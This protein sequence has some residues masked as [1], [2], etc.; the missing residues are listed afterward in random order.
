MLGGFISV[1]VEE[2]CSNEVVDSRFN[3]H[4]LVFW[5]ELSCVS[6]CNIWRWYRTFQKVCGSSEREGSLGHIGAV[7]LHSIPASIRHP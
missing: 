6:D 1:E 4:L 5:R 7:K 2:R 3:K